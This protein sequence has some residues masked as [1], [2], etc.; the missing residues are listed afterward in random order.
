M[1][2]GF[3]RDACS[4]P[5]GIVSL[6]CLSHLSAGEL[7]PPARQEH[8][9]RSLLPQ[10]AAAYEADQGVCGGSG[11]EAPAAA[12]TAAAS[13]RD[14]N[15][16]RQM[17]MLSEKEHIAADEPCVCMPDSCG[18]E[19]MCWEERLFFFPTSVPCCVDLQL[20]AATR[21]RRRHHCRNGS[22]ISCTR[23]RPSTTAVGVLSPHRGGDDPSWLCPRGGARTNTLVT[24]NSRHHQKTRPKR[25]TP[26]EPPGS[27]ASTLGRRR[28]AP[29]V[30]GHDDERDPLTAGSEWG[31]ARRDA[32]ARTLLPK[33]WHVAVICA[34]FVGAVY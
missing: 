20:T 14:S 12:V 3:Q 1:G 34:D 4:S 17:T 6:I 28:L 9:L 23:R 2:M 33:V 26:P 19:E 15:M 8:L 31:R 27:R 7:D 29:C 18:Q 10:Q 13:K 11:G 5:G 25:A 32:R 22:V 16:K 30:G 21:G 24:S